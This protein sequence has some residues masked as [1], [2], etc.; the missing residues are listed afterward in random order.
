MLF[1][2]C[3]PLE[4]SQVC[5]VPIPPPPFIRDAPC[6]PC[7]RQRLGGACPEIG[8]RSSRVASP[9]LF[10]LALGKPCLARRVMPCRLHSDLCVG[11]A[12]VLKV[13]CNPPSVSQSALLQV[14]LVGGGSASRTSRHAAAKTD[15]QRSGRTLAARLSQ[16]AS[17]LH[18]IA[19]LPTR[20]RAAMS[21]AQ[22]PS[23]DLLEEI[24][25]RFIL[26]LPATELE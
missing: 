16:S 20:Q 7:S 9:R 8:P 3:N 5:C 12:G 4:S 24:C 1:A 11:S 13:T 19:P 2:T 18:L 23:A 14:R 22:L 25:V 21:P 10:W 17:S 26:T 15:E 6:G